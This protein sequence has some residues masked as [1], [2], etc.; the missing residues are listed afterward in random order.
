LF[1][2]GIIPGALMML[3]LASYC[4]W[5]NRHIRVPFSEFS[6]REVGAALRESWLDIPLPI[7]VLGGIYGGFFAV[8]EAAAVTAVYTVIT[9]VLLRRDISITRL[10]GIMRQSM[11]LVGAILLIL[12]VS[13][14]STNVL[15]DAQ[16]PERLVAVITGFVGGQLSF[17]VLLFLFLLALG[18]LLDIFSALV[19]V[20]PLIVPVAMQYGVSPVHL[21]ILFVANMELGYL[22]P[23]MGRN[24]VVSSYRFDQP[25]LRVYAATLPF[26]LVLLL[27]VV[28]ITFWPELSLWMLEQ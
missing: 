1:L 25:I 8:S 2:A 16:I 12:G 6:W 20:V 21:G 23:P 13:L 4:L 3:G 27:A 9:E 22:A 7:V 28:A 10:P 17:L 24:L 19:L 14:A 18:A 26:L 15:I 11:V 5:V